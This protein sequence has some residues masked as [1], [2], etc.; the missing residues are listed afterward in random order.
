MSSKQADTQH[1]EMNGRIP[2]FRHI[3]GTHPVNAA[4]AL[5]HGVC[6]DP[7]GSAMFYELVTQVKGHLLKRNCARE[8]EYVCRCTTR[9]PILV[10]SSP[11]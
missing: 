4:S 9:S 5:A 7:G 8:Y 3:L 11:Q 2:D 10:P 6:S 1:D